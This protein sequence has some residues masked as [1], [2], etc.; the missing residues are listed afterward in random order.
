[1]DTTNTWTNTAKTLHWL[2]AFLLLAVWASVEL[3]EQVPRGNPWRDY[4]IIA[5]FTLGAS[6]L[7]VMVIRLVWRASHRPPAPLGGRLQQRLA[8]AVHGLLYLAVL[9]MPVT[10]LLMRQLDGK[11]TPLPAGLAIPAWLP[12]N[13]ALAERLE[14]LHKEWL[15]NALLALI[16]LHVAGALW[17]HWVDRDATLKRMLPG[18][19]PR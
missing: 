15:W 3:H 2:I 9:A 13:T 18:R 7:A 4:W 5:H 6:A 10:G 19:R 17:H 8:T 14:D 11:S 1:M 16:V 12:A